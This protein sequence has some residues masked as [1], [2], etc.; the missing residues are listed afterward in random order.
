MTSCSHCH[1]IVVERRNSLKSK[2]AKV[3][4]KKNIEI[5]LKLK[6]N[7]FLFLLFGKWGDKFLKIRVGNFI[8]RLLNQNNRDLKQG[9]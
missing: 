5:E 4:K 1:V 6:R 2:A 8:N 3:K 9:D 7:H